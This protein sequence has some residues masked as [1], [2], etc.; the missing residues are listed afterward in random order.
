[1]LLHYLFLLGISVEAISGAIAA[2][3]KKM[4]FFGVIFIGCVAGLGGGVVRDVMFDLHPTTW[5]A[6]P[7]YLLYTAGFALLTICIPA[8][9]TRVTKLFLVFDALGLAAFTIIT[10]Q[11]LLTHGMPEVV[12]ILGGLIT[13]ISGGMLRDILCNDIPLVLRHELY[14]VVSLMG[15]LLY[16]ILDH[17]QI[18]HN[19]SVI[20]TVLFIFI[21]RLLAIRFHI[22]VPK[23]NYTD[24]LNKRK[25]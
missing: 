11:R 22:E 17:L 8:K 20:I 19:L 6:H 18:N 9:L 25:K 24:S 15:A 1:M 7:E 21:V 12:A 13:G 14:A 10:T 2:G 4:D 23:F 3:R 16:V 5:V